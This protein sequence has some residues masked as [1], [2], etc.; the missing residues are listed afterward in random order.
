[1]ELWTLGWEWPKLCN[2]VGFD[3]FERWVVSSLKSPKMVIIVLQG[4]CKGIE[5][6]CMIVG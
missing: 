2:I 5:L 1:M 4:M 6:W 3:Q